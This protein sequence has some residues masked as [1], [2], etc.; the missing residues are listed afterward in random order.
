MG[1]ILPI[2]GAT[3]FIEYHYEINIDVYL[4]IFDVK[5]TIRTYNLRRYAP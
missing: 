4:D 1:A 2:T 3:K 5:V